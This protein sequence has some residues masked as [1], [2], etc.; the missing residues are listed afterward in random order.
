MKTFN[1]T[2]IKLFLIK[3]NEY[4]QVNYGHLSKG[5][6]SYESPII[7]TASYESTKRQSEKK[8]GEELYCEI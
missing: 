2:N 8:R 6:F 3:I 7:S 4:F 5:I 1:N